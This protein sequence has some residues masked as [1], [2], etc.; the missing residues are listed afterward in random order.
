M[1]TGWSMS[2]YAGLPYVRVTSR[3]FFLLKELNKLG[4]D[5][6]LFTSD[7]NHQTTPPEFSGKSHYHTVEN[8]PFLWLKTF[9]FKRSESIMRILSWLHFEWQLISLN[10]SK[11]HKPD[12]VIASSLSLLTIL[13]GLYFKK[14]YKAKLI[15]EI[16]DIWPLSIIDEGNYSPSNPAVRFLSWIERLGYHH[17]DA[18]IGTMPNLAAH[19]NDVL[20]Y[21]KPHIYCIPQGYDKEADKHFTA[22]DDEFVKTYV[23]EGKFTVCYAGTVGLTN[24]LDKMMDAAKQLSGKNPDI[25]FLIVGEGD[26]RES[27]IEQAKQLENV[28]I[29][30]PI[31]N[32]QVHSLLSQHA[33]LLF[34][35]V[36]K[37]KLWHYGQSLN[38]L[39]DY[40][41]AGKPIIAAYD[42]YQS[43]INE[44]D[45]GSFI[46]PDDADALAQ[47]IER[48]AA[49]PETERTQ[50]GNRA[51]HWIKENRSFDKLG[52]ELSSIIE[53]ISS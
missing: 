52:K 53:T 28:T 32:T 33:D 21:Q 13:S 4:Y 26:A 22:I 2:K 20:G 15:V 43:M 1:T 35:A 6:I 46:D 37:S 27:L 44:A 17:A 8:V 36:T 18:I 29:A 50:I 12:I 48:Y 7:S 3:A 30:P 16:R 11:F 5:G 23:P 34:L 45:C 38:K 40:M 10:K 14:R 31:P 25:H 19:V 42:G 47:E 51:A 24:S 39:V 41:R 49:M 9:K